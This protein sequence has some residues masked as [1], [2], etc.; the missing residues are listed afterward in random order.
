MPNL[1]PKTTLPS[2]TYQRRRWLSLIIIILLGYV[3]FQALS[4]DCI[5]FSRV[6]IVDCRESEPFGYWTSFFVVLSILFGLALVFLSSFGKQDPV[7]HQ[8]QE[9]DLSNWAN[10]FSLPE[11]IQQQARLPKLAKFLLIVSLC[12]MLFVLFRFGAFRDLIRLS[13]FAFILV[14]F[15]IG[16]TMLIQWLGEQIKIND[17]GIYRYRIL[18][19]WQH[20]AWNEITHVKLDGDFFE[21]NYSI[22]IFKNNSRIIFTPGSFHQDKAKFIEACQWILQQAILHQVEIRLPPDGLDDWL[23]AVQKK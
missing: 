22:K 1:K 3:I 19:G 9:D 21:K 10:Q 4:E 14:P 6:G 16:I 17:K 5:E 13:M 18:L 23:A 2:T 8:E 11:N 20:W 7:I 12:F 15:G